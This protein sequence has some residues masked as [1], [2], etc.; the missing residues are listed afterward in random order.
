MTGRGM[1][2][3]GRRNPRQVWGGRSGAGGGKGRAGGGERG[4][5]GRAAGGGG[6]ERSQSSTEL[7]SERASDLSAGPRTSGRKAARSARG[8]EERARRAPRA[9]A[10]AL[11]KAPCGAPAGT[12]RGRGRHGPAARGAGALG[13]RRGAPRLVAAAAT[14]RSRAPRPLQPPPGPPPAHEPRHQSLRR[15]G[16]RGASKM[17]FHPV[18][19]ALMYRGIYTV[20]NLLSEQRPVDIPEDE[21]EGECP[22]GPLP[23]GPPTWARGRGRFAARSCA[24]LQDRSAPGAPRW[25]VARAEGGPAPARVAPRAAET[26]RAPQRAVTVRQRG[27]LGWGSALS[28]QHRPG[29]STRI[30]IPSAALARGSLLALTFR[31]C[32]FKNSICSGSRRRGEGDCPASAPCGAAPPLPCS[33][34]GTPSPALRE[35]SPGGDW[36]AQSR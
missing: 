32:R 2:P 3:K 11:G 17:P 34:A 7:A 24:R 30:L 27:G 4:G 6:G 21:L 12:G 36:A 25:G 23:A 31:S 10:G 35:G 9:A 16:G 19:A 14:L 8:T 20:P 15:A 1:G 22:P 28:P 18:T 29:R 5:G 13:P 33:P 26:C